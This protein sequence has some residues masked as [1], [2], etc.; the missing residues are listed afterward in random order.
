MEIKR[1]IPLNKRDHLSIIRMY[2]IASAILVPHVLWTNIIFFFFFVP[3]SNELEI[4]DTSCIFILLYGSLS[5]FII[6]PIIG[7]CSN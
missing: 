4:S 6:S 3:K 2:G 5:G 7:A 1:K